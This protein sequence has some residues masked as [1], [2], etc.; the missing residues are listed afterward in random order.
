MYN[1]Q[2]VNITIG[3]SALSKA[4]DA[5]K[6]GMDVQEAASTYKVSVEEINQELQSGLN[7]NVAEEEGVGDL[8]SFSNVP[9]KEEDSD[10]SLG[11]ALGLGT[12]VAATAGLV[13]RKK[14]GVLFGQFSKIENWL[15]LRK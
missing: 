8:T 3:R 5:V 11:W 12:A 2:V 4:V 10:S 1:Q 13:F 15:N 6:S 14:L 7:G 9:Q